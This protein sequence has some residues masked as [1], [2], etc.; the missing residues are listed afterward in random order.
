MFAARESVQESLGFS[1]F[2]LVFVHSVHGVLK[3]LKECWLQE[4]SKNDNLL[5]YVF[6]FRTRLTETSELSRENLHIFLIHLYL[7]R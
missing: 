6:Q 3:L 5:Y 1:P 2:E 7:C 4:F